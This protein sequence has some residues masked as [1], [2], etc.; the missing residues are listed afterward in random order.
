M[1]GPRT[2]NLIA[3]LVNGTPD[4]Y[5]R[6]LT[7]TRCVRKWAKAKGLYSNK[8]GY[9]GGVNINIMV[10]HVVQRLP[11]VAASRLLRMFFSIY[12]IWYLREVS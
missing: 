5:Q 4:R 12:K 6:F 9:L 11:D 3:R 8:M 7:V 1:N 2:T 10:A